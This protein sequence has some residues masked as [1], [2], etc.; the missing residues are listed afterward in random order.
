MP[1]LKSKRA[2]R[3]LDEERVREVRERGAA[4][5]GAS[6]PVFRASWW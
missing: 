4:A 3:V 6:Q 1:R 2:R 5:H